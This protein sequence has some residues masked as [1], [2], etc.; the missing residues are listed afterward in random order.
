MTK[1]SKTQ[2]KVLGAIARVKEMECGTSELRSSTARVLREKGLIE[3]ATSEGPRNESYRSIISGKWRSKLV[4]GYTTFRITEA[5]RL[6]LARRG[7]DQSDWFEAAIEDAKRLEASWAP[8]DADESA[9][10]AE[11]VRELEALRSRVN[12]ATS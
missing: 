1:L 3:V 2:L 4:S 11:K 12:E 5:G 9:L 10:W 7:D 8:R 6:E